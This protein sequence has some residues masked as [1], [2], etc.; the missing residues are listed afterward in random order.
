MII[1]CLVFTFTQE[2]TRWV[3]VS[4]SLLLESHVVE[5]L[6]ASTAQIHTPNLM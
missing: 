3:W 2:L 5:E 4:L 6:V 1:V